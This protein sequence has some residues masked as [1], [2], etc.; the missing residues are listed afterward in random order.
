MRKIIS[1]I[2]IAIVLLSG[3]G[4]G[5]QT[6][7]AAT[8]NEDPCQS[9]ID[10]VQQYSDEL[11]N[12]QGGT[13]NL[14]DAQDL[15]MDAID[16]AL[17]CINNNPTSNGSSTSTPSYSGN[18]NNSS[19]LLDRD[20][21][22]DIEGA[23]VYAQDN[24]QQFL[25]ILTSNDFKSESMANNFGTYGNEFNSKSIFNEFGTYGNE[26]S[27]YS[28][29]NEFS[30]NPPKIVKNGKLL[31]Y[32]T[33]NE[34]KNGAVN[35]ILALNCIMDL[36]DDRLEP[37]LSFIPAQSEGVNGFPLTSSGYLSL[38]ATCPTNSYL[39]SNG[40]CYCDTKY[41]WNSSTEKCTEIV[42]Q[43][44]DPTNSYLGNDDICYCKS[45]LVWSD[46]KCITPSISTTN[47]VGTQSNILETNTKFEEDVS[48]SQFKDSILSLREKDIISGY[49]DGT[50]K[51]FNP[52]NRAE[53]IKIV[54]GAG[55]SA[56]IIN[57]CT[58]EHFTDVSSSDWFNNY[59][60][61]AKTRNIIDGYPDGT[62][63]PEQNIN[64]AEALKITLKAFDIETRTANSGEAW[65][66][67]FTEYAKGNNYW[68]NTFDSSS[69]QLTRE[70]MAELVHRI[71]NK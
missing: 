1:M 42:L 32:L 40:N 53:F 16:E 70:D 62:F 26:F 12:V 33:T 15:W 3:I 55:F 71:M 5:I 68:I 52:I 67:P 23:S 58:A 9:E 34:Y 14:L 36:S 35:P 59:V 64:V 4:I 38:P 48:Q 60:C 39:S 66:A 8:Q 24:N 43:C 27:S 51:P 61:I 37:F 47:E 50:F 21:C 19:S 31:G 45:G 17:I 54:I 6:A 57:A 49:E 46:K 28:P 18:Y 20:I 30:S 69:R 25:G 22:Y 56:N 29:W 11:D 13:Q 2:V 44:P 10:L 41:E 7:N 63:R 65:Y